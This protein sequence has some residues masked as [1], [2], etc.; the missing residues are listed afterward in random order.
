MYTKVHQKM[1][2][3]VLIIYDVIPSKRG[4]LLANHSE[5]LVETSRNLSMYAKVHHKI[6]SGVLMIDDV[7]P[8]KK[9]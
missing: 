4:D 5:H 3:S 9:G 2:S 8:M 1:L 6:F 7:I